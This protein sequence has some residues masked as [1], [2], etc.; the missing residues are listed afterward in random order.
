MASQSNKELEQRIALLEQQLREKDERLSLM[1]SDF[2]SDGK[3]THSLGTVVDI[4][5]RLQ[6]EN[7]LKEY[8]K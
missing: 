4:T 2:D 8:L 1:K 7:E 6:I 3:P 5:E